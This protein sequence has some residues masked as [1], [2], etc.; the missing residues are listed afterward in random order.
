[1]STA[2]TTTVVVP[3]SIAIAVFPLFFALVAFK[4]DS[5]YDPEKGHAMTDDELKAIEAKIAEFNAQKTKFES[6]AKAFEEKLTAMTASRDELQTKIDGI[7]APNTK[8]QQG[9]LQRR[10]GGLNRGKRKLRRL[11]KN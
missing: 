5:N 8:Q 4:T 11:I 9:N 1:V 2:F 6:D 10:Y 7:A 3:I